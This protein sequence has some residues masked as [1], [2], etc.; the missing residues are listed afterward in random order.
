MELPKGLN[1]LTFEEEGKSFYYDGNNGVLSETTPLMNEVFKNCDK[2]YGYIVKE[3]RKRYEE[4]EINDQ[5]I[6]LEGLVE[7]GLFSPKADVVY[8][9][10]KKYSEVTEEEWSKGHGLICI[11]LN[12][13]YDCNLRCKYCFGDGGSYGFE[14]ELMS[15]DVAKKCIDYWFEH[16]NKN[17]KTVYVTFFGG[18]PLLNQSVLKFS[19]DYINKYFEGKDVEVIYSIT[20]NGTIVNDEIID[21][22]IKNNINPLISIDG[23]KEVQN[24][25]RPFASGAGSFDAVRKN[26]LKL[27]EHFNFLRARMTVTK[28][29]VKYFKQ[30]VEEI[31]EMGIEYVMYDVVASKAELLR[32]TE[33][34]MESLNKQISE[35]TEI[36]YNNIISNK[37]RVLWSLLKPAVKI[38]D[39]SM[40]GSCSLY[41]LTTIIFD[42]KGN[43]YKCHRLAGDNSFKVGDLD[44]GVDWQLFSKKLSKPEIEKCKSCWARAVCQDGCSHINYVYSDDNNLN[45]PYDLWCKHNK[46]IIEKSLRLY[47]RLLLNNKEA[48]DKFFKKIK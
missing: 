28:E 16:L 43:M 8:S 22:F 46:F 10:Y 33:E 23:I 21:I 19:I 35:L 45:A 6:E 4:N 18:E 34:D 20:T 39:R 31:W 29:N 44:S 41:G 26:V 24:C 40:N 30:S 15:L 17:A 25:N 47:T 48:F 12:I 7:K 32:V 11:W 2:E 27:K 36:T 3:L 13:S 14:K 38:N 1:L 37:N 42:P 9:K 5:F